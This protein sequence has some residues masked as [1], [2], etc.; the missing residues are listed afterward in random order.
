M[1]D[2]GN[3]DRGTVDRIGRQRG[4]IDLADLWWER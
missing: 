4:M 2:T 1:T 3:I